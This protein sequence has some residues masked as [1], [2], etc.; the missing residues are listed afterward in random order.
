MKALKISASFLGS[1]LA[2][3]LVAAQDY[4]VYS[5]GV[6]GTGGTAFTVGAPFLSFVNYSAPD[7]FVYAVST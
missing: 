2:I 1:I 3:T 4:T 6:P 5:I 7:S